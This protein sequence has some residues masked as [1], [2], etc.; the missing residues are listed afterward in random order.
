M[1]AQGNFIKTQ[2]RVYAATDAELGDLD[3]VE[4]TSDRTPT[5]DLA[6]EIAAQFPKSVGLRAHR[7][8]GRRGATETGEVVLRVGLSPTKPNQ[9]VN[10]DGVKRYRAFRQRA[11]RLGHEV[12]YDAGRFQ[13]F[14]DDVI[15]S[16]ADFE[17]RLWAQSVYPRERG[18]R[19]AKMWSRQER[20]VW[21]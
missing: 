7:F 13:G 15:S 1:S 17:N 5:P 8:I 4:A 6:Q 21:P 10:Q 18:V 14:P 12:Q 3:Y 16:E 9:G 2:F 20:P 19:K 11:E